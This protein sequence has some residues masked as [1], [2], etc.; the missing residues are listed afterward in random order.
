MINAA[1]DVLQFVFVLV[2]WI[3]TKGFTLEE[4]DRLIDGTKHSSVPDI[5][6]LQNGTAVLEGKGV[7]S[8]GVEVDNVQATKEVKT[9]VTPTVN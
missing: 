1:W 4:I 6:D 3:E 5:V 9:V 7:D 2:F 8:T